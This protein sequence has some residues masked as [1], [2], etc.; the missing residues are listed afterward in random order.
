VDETVPFAEFKRLK[1]RVGQVKEVRDH[2][3]AD[4]LF[5]IRVDLGDEERQLVAGL[6]GYYGAEEMVGKKVVVVTNLEAAKLRGVESRGMLLAAQ[7][8]EVVSLLT[9]DKEVPAGSDVL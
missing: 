1:F 4:K 8:G 6:K 7:S 9:V 3:N 5:V 2:P